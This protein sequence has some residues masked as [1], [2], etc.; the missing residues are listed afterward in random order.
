MNSD[1]TAL[2]CHKDKL[3]FLYEELSLK[4]EDIENLEE[5]ALNSYG[6]IAARKKTEI[7]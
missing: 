5:Q 7:L 6:L 1:D 3:E 4:V 2:D